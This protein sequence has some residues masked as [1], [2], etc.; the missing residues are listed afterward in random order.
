MAA[1]RRLAAADQRLWESKA[2]LF[3]Q[4]SLSGSTGT[5]TAELRDV[6]DTD[7]SVWTLAGNLAQPIF[8]GGRLLAGVDVSK[9]QVKEATFSF[10]STALQAFGEVEFG[11]TSEAILKQREE[12]TMEAAA[13]SA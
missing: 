12:H 7:F 4:I 3:P 1:E 8:Q 6:V 10:V 11:L 2:A 13:Q 9:A 5:S